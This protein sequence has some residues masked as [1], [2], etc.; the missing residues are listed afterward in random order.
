MTPIIHQHDVDASNRIL[1]ELVDPVQI[2][3]RMRL[4]AVA[5]L[6]EQ[7]SVNGYSPVEIYKA[8]HKAAQE[9]IE[10]VRKGVRVE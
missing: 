5:G 4:R 3:V 8:E 10:G 1:G 9:I 2:W 6:I 7:M